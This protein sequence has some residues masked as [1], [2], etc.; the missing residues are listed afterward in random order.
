MEKIE[1]IRLNDKFQILKI[2]DKFSLCLPSLSCGK[3][4]REGISQKF[5]SHAEFWTILIQEEVVGF[6]SFY[7]NNHS[8]KIAYISMIAVKNGF[9][10]SG[11]GYLLLEKSENISKKNGMKKIKLEVSKENIGAIEFYMRNGFLFYE[12]GEETLFM[13]KNL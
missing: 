7:A 8:E 11:I 4:Q 2:L 1:Y 9:R 3:K 13:I 12:E 5:A 10:R 6:I